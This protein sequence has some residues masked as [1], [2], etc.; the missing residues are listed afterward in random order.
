M[1]SGVSLYALGALALATRSFERR[2]ERRLVAIAK[3]TASS[4]WVEP[5]ALKEMKAN[6]LNNALMKEHGDTAKDGKEGSPGGEL[7]LGLE[8]LELPATSTKKPPAAK[9]PPPT[10]TPKKPA[11][12]PKEPEPE[13]EVDRSDWIVRGADNNLSTAWIEDAPDADALELADRHRPGHVVGHDQIDAREAEL[14]KRV[15]AWRERLLVE[16][17]PALEELERWRPGIDRDEWAR[18][19]SAAQAERARTGASG[20][21]SR[22][23]F[24]ALRALFDQESA[25]G[26]L[27][28]S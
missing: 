3:V 21:A 16:G 19:L 2:G 6:A 24:R 23:L 7:E 1:S 22:E 8:D 4:A 17:G 12:A 11:K 18:R 13:I 5:S 28:N 26:S 27:P 25:P 20:V 14:F 9:K 15:E 10:T